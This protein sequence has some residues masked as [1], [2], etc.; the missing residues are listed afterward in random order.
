MEKFVHQIPQQKKPIVTAKNIEHITVVLVIYAISIPFFPQKYVWSTLLISFLWWGF[1]YLFYKT[2]EFKMTSEPERNKGLEVTFWISTIFFILMG[3]LQLVYPVFQRMSWK[4][5]FLF[6]CSFFD[7]EIFVPTEID[8]GSLNHTVRHLLY[9]SR[10][11][12][13]SR[14]QGYPISEP[15][16]RCSWNV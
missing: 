8:C 4:T 16:Y 15:E 1:A 9:F 2:R 14:F 13:F 12:C 11:R 7:I 6:K 10:L 5:P 3:I